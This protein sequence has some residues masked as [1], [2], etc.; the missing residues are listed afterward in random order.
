MMHKILVWKFTTIKEANEK[1]HQ[2]SHRFLK[3]FIFWSSANVQV[4]WFHSWEFFNTIFVSSHM[5]P[6][7]PESTLYEHGIWYISDTARNR[8]H[9]LFRPKCAPIPLGHSD[10]SYWISLHVPTEDV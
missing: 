8:T 7:N 5:Y 3:Y 6:E 1:L 2:G 10:K 4:C 9:N